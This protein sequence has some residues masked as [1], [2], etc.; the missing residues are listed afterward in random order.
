MN[1]FVG[2][3]SSD[4][5]K[6]DTLKMAGSIVESLATSG[7]YD[8]VIGGNTGGIMRLCYNT[9][10]DNNRMI[11]GVVASVYKEDLESMDCDLSIVAENTFDRSRQI[12]EQ[13]D[14]ML[15]LPGGIGTEAEF[16]GMLEEKRT[17]NVDIPM[18]IYNEDKS[19]DP[20]LKLLDYIYEN[21]F[22]SK[23]ESKHYQVVY[24]EEELFD[25]LD[26]IK[27]KDKI[28]LKK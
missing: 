23:D 7:D 2:C 5:I 15:F 27:N 20:T 17:Y 9:F 3:S 8:L 21:K 13:S 16:F 26:Q 10:K 24:S 19:F 22:S 11:S 1:L 4:D 6:L 18:I 28:N 14:I 12:M 25:C